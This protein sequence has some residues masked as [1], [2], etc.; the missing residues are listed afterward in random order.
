MGLL[1]GLS[2]FKCY[3]GKKGTP[4]VPDR[5]HRMQVFRAM[6]P[7]TFANTVFRFDKNGKRIQ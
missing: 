7:T 1:T 4:Q 2:L 5:D 3:P 6:T